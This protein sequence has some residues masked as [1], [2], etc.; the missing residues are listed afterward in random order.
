MHSSNE[1]P[2]ED[3]SVAWRGFHRPVTQRCAEVLINAADVARSFGHD[4]TGTEHLL[5][6]MLRTPDT[7]AESVLASLAD[8]AVIARECEHRLRSVSA[9]NLGGDPTFTRTRQLD[10]VIRRA[11][12]HAS[13]RA[14][15]AV[16]TRH[17]LHGVVDDESTLAYE[18]LVAGKVSPGAV[19]DALSRS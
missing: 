4:Y 14:S 8:P 19:S 11:E 10:A 6:A 18:I 17:L 7:G 2:R 3:G 9:P 1:S 12:I 5:L 15:T 16:D 13:A